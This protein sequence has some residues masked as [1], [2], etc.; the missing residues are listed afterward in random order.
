MFNCL[1]L[2]AERAQPL[3]PRLYQRTY[4][5]TYGRRPSPVDQPVTMPDTL[6]VSEMLTLVSSPKAERN[7]DSVIAG[8]VHRA[9]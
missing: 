7:S 1:W 6:R 5:R 4:G 3:P 9:A 2:R 8:T